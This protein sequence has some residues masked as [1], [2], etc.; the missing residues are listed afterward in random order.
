MGTLQCFNNMAEAEMVEKTAASEPSVMTSDTKP[1][2]G[3]GSTMIVVLSVLFAIAG[4]A[5]LV[6]AGVVAPGMAVPDANQW[7][8]LKVL[9]D[10]SDGVLMTLENETAAPGMP[11]GGVLSKTWEE[12]T[13]INVPFDTVFAALGCACLSLASMCFFANSTLQQEQGSPKMH[14]LSC[15]IQEGAKNFMLEE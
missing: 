9:R 1:V 13:V 8:K 6:V 5:F 3:A 4:I 10:M 7:I 12:R 11:A 2:A 15:I 14:E